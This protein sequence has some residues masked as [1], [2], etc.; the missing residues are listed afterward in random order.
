M[1][2]DY[3]INGNNVVVRLGGELDLVLAAEFKRLVDDLLDRRKAKNLYVNLERVTFLDS[4]F[5]GALLGRYRR[6]NQI[7]GRMGIVRP[8]A[9]IRPTLELS[10]ILRTMEE[11]PAEPQD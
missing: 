6:I 2:L 4:S 7:G 11:L 9:A 5:L 3:Q 8:P 10:G 1:S